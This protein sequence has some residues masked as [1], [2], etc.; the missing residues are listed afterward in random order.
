MKTTHIILI[1]VLA[2]A[3]GAVVSLVGDSGSYS[4]FDFAK[5]HEDNKF[6]I[7]G[8]LDTTEAITYNAIENPD[9][10]SFYMLDSKG[11]KHKV[12]VKKAKPQDFEKSVQ[13]VVKGNMT[14]SA[15]VADEVL[16]K[17]PSKYEGEGMPQKVN[18]NIKVMN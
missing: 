13:V 2:V 11:K 5:K 6:S 3:I 16:M 15:F 18:K 10:F 17:C 4:D 12:F 1:I 7:V 8:A 9:M 14:D